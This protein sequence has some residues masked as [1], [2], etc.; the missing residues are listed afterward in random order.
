MIFIWRILYGVPVA[1]AFMVF[2]VFQLRFQFAQ[3]KGRPSPNWTLRETVAIAV[4]IGWLLLDTA[5]VRWQLWPEL[6][7]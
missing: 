6:S 7:H 3:A 5:I 4:L 1:V 2:L